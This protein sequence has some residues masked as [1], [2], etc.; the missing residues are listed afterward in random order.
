M[1]KCVN[2]NPLWDK[3]FSG[4]CPL[5]PTN[6]RILRSL[7][8]F[9]SPPFWQRLKP[10]SFARQKRGPVRLFCSWCKQKMR[11]AIIVADHCTGSPIMNTVLVLVDVIAIREHFRRRALAINVPSKRVIWHYVRMLWHLFCFCA[12]I[13]CIP[14]SSS[15]LCNVPLHRKSISYKCHISETCLNK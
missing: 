4:N 15:Q 14:Q 10:S 11:S 13:K 2:E 9:V 12:H 5:T 7:I 6:E 8:E 1:C 3:L